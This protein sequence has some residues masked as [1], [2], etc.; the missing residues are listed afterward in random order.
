MSQSDTD[1]INPEWLAE[2]EAAAARPLDLR[3]KYAF[4]R[5][6]RPVLDD[7]PYRAF[8]STAEYRDWCNRNLPR[9]LGYASD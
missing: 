8:D 1:E 5:T 6:Y 7:V 2:F 4:I 3:L 9:W